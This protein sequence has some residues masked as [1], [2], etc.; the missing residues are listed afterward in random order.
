MKVRI[1][2]NTI[3]HF[4]EW[5]AVV[6]SIV[7]VGFTLDW[8]GHVYKMCWFRDYGASVTVALPGGRK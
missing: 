8:L 7:V 3:W 5:I 6:I 4:C 2:A 1:R